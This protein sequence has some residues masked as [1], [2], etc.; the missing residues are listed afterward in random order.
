MQCGWV[1]FREKTNSEVVIGCL[2]NTDKRD[3]VVGKGNR[4]ERLKENVRKS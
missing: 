2:M 3:W 4:R 1:D